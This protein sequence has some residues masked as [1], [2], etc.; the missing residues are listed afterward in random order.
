[1][2]EL[3]S[4]LARIGTPTEGPAH[5]WLVE[6]VDW[7]RPAR[8]QAPA[9][10]A[11]RLDRLCDRLQN[12]PPAAA[13]LA[14]HLFSCFAGRRQRHLLAETGVF[15][16]GG[17]FGGLAA[18]IGRRLL[19]PVPEPGLWIDLLGELFHQSAD[20]RWVEAAGTRRWA[21]LIGLIASA[22]RS[23]PAAVAGHAR[24][25][26][27][28]LEALRLLA[29][30]LA[31]LGSHPELLRYHAHGDQTDA[32]F[33]D[34]AAALL[35]WCDAMQARPAPHDAGSGAAKATHDVLRA[36]AT[37]LAVALERCDA[38][39]DEVR[40]LA[41]AQGTS[42]ALT[43]RLR[44]GRASTAR[45][46]RLVAIVQQASQ[47]A[48]AAA[49]ETAVLLIELVRGECKRDSLRELLA[50]STDLLALQVTEN[51][52]RTGEHYVTTDRAGWLAMAR[53]AMGAGSIVG[54]MALVKILLASL[55]LPPFWEALA[56][57]LNYAIGFVL[58]HALH[59]TIATKQPAM[60]AAHIAAAI[61]EGRD[62]DLAANLE[63]LVTLTA[64]VSRTQLV[65]I[66][67]NVL[68]ALP[69]SLLIAWVWLTATG[70]PVTEAGKSAR[71]LADLHPWA[72]AALPHAAIAGLCLFL[73]GIISG[74][75]DNRCVHARVPARIAHHRALNRLL[76][77]QR[78]LGLA[79]Y[80]EHNHGA[81]A[82]NIAFGLMLGY[83]GF[84]GTMLGLPL[85]IRHVTFAAANLA[86]GAVGL[87][88]T[89]APLE[90]AI[91][92]LGVALIGLVN[93][94]VSFGLAFWTALK[95]RGLRIGQARAFWTVLGRRLRT[96]PGSFV[97]PPPGTTSSR[98]R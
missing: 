5:G 19:P 8:G 2:R 65:A 35:D 73:S 94:G 40:Q 21:R 62:R 48:T 49:D 28:G 77:S 51:A 66:A 74:Y 87:Q 55:H 25:R 46:R 75:F 43:L 96:D 98:N 68:I 82:G 95:A 27:E 16:E 30:R 80:I 31:A 61:D 12:D 10:A 17:F 71:L 15:V 53:S 83:V 9:A 70:A 32:P 58:V 64:Q 50:R 26:I 39:L 78:T 89:A 33:L 38:V 22:P 45:I 23:L 84:I 91:T 72:S 1:M 47:A 57:G 97:L 36:A 63:R 42:T 69:V 6:L 29:H 56:F 52:S 4:L 20:D 41:H 13:R 76:G 60:T 54:M 92:A 86:Y 44:E 18:R 88:G 34:Q 67:G 79:H 7:L 14:D 3:D 11:E 93:L 85:D 59:F 24:L 90:L 37:R 81:I